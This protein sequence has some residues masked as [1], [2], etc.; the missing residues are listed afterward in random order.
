MDIFQRDRAGEQ[1]FITDPEHDKI[2]NIILESQKII[3]EMNSSYK[4]PEEIRELFSKLINSK[5]DESVWLMPPFYTDFGRNIKLG[6]GVFINHACTFMDR[7]TITIEDDVFIAP[8]V[9]L[10]TTNHPTNPQQRKSTVSKPIVIKKNVWI[11][12]NATVLG[13][14]TIGE[15]SIVSAG[16]VVTKDVPPNVIVAG[17]PAKIIK[18]INSAQQGI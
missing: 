16:A 17:L 14:V 10:I 6:K 9:N 18:R 2:K 12:I 7:G 1:I 8:K 5:I 3:A 11:G 15:N 4:S 13:N